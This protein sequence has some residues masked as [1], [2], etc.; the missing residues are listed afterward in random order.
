MKTDIVIH[1]T[2]VD[3]PDAAAISLT[4]LPALASC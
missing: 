4:V 1:K 3:G 2:F